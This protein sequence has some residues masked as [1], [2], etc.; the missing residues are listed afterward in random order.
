[1]SPAI[2][3][4]LTDNQRASLLSFT[5]SCPTSPFDFSKRSSLDLIT[6]PSEDRDWRTWLADEFP[7]YVR[8]PFAARHTRLWQWVDALR[9]RIR[10]RPC[11]ELW[12]RGGAKSTT[13]ELGCAWAGRQLKR[14]FGLYVSGIQDQA[15]KHIGS[16][17]T[18]FEHLGIE[19]AVNEYGS[20]KGWTRQMLRTAH[21]F[22]MLS[23][24]L[25]KGVRGVKLDELR[26]DF[27]VLDDVD[28]RHDT[29]A[30]VQ[31]KIEIIT[32]NIL[33]A[34]SADCAILFVQNIIHGNSIAARLADGSADF[35][36][37]RLPVH[38]EKAVNGLQYALRQRDDSTSYYVI[39]AGTATWPGQSLET[40]AAQLNDW[41]LT[42]FLREA[43]HDVA[44]AGRYYETWNDDVHVIAPRAIP[45]DATVWAAFDYGF[46]HN[47]SFGVYAAVD[48]DVFKIGEHVR[49]KWPV[50]DHAAAMDDLLEQL[51]IEKARLRAIVAGR[52]AFD[53]S[54]DS[55][56][57]SIADQYAAHG[58]TMTKA[59]IDRINGWAAL[60]E[61]LGNPD[62]QHRP[63]FY[64]FNTCP[65]TAAQLK[66][67]VHDP[68]RTEDV[69]K[70]D[71]DADGNGGDD[72]ADETRYGLMFYR[73]ALVVTRPKTPK[74]NLFKGY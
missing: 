25:D 54:K 62:V 36:L 18:L 35:L 24:G 32:E 16:V 59:N 7:L 14:R 60:R 69:L 15:D 39:T 55:S 27:I 1:M 68:K 4:T 44:H 9:P 40:C 56:G 10:P 65:V 8:A 19:R 51:G 53:G 23:I 29:P 46:A 21:G 33:P 2:Q 42:A 72:A 3:T 11:V 6:L 70:V 30:A 73:P 45:G 71:A 50:R 17:A 48:G 38:I 26:P 20:S 37:D 63:T 22:N 64:V 58:Y 47:T 28:S 34:G 49:N 52:D 57:K 12:G 67:V 43:Q 13:T 74:P 5:G 61:R 66:A 31:K 41:G